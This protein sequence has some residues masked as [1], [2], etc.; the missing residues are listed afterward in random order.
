[1]RLK[2]YNNRNRLRWQADVKSREEAKELFL[3]KSKT[4]DYGYLFIESSMREEVLRPRYKHTNDRI[5][6][7]ENGRILSRREIAVLGCNQF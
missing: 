1:M 4:T 5:I 7:N 6:K 3:E 2:I